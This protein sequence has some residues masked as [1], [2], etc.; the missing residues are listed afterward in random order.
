[1]RW[2]EELPERILPLSAYL[3]LRHGVYARNHT[4]IRALRVG[5]CRARTGNVLDPRLPLRCFRRR[6]KAGP[7]LCGAMMPNDLHSPVDFRVLADDLRVTKSPA[8]K[9]RRATDSVDERVSE[10]GRSIEN[11]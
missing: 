1:M 11:A 9:R 2:R 8:R 6:R 4:N 7:E 10:F 3:Q 5:F